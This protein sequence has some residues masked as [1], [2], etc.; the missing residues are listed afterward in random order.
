MSFVDLEREVSIIIPAYNEETY[1]DR[2]LSSLQQ[3]DFEKKRYEIIVVDN[4]STDN[5]P[6]VA[7]KYGV[8]I[9]SFPEGE[10]IAAV[11]NK[12]ASV[13][14]G[15]ILA[16]LDA[17]CLVSEN[18]LNSAIN[19]LQGDIGC[20]GSRPVAPLADSTWV[21]R[22]WGQIL[23]KSL[24]K[25]V[26]TDWLSSSNL[27]VLSDY[28]HKIN[29]FDERLETGEDA[30]FGFRLK[31]FTKILYD[32]SVKAFHLKEPKTLIDFII[33]EI[34]HGKSNIKGF[35]L[36]G[37]P[38]S[39]LLSVALPTI[40]FVSAILFIIGIMFSRLLLLVGF[41]VLILI[42]AIMTVRNIKRVGISA[43]LVP[44]YAINTSY[45]LGR[46]ISVV[47]SILDLLKRK[48]R[49]QML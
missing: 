37:F 29:G 15:C 6:F 13:A 16:F 32:P 17:D 36:H 39:E 49:K 34:W 5:T 21:Q 46:A 43:L 25:A 20:V 27:I 26:P 40:Y 44:C 23:P 18:W 9:I 2:C 33:K 22:C 28:F 45:I 7:E 35:V 48:N 12:G 3:M 38:L 1:L 24:D 42:P 14:S 47:P 4:G 30:D 31:G 10:T 8:T 11:R 41:A 19:C